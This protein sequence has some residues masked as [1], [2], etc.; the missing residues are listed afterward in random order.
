MKKDEPCPDSPDSIFR[1]PSLSPPN[2]LISPN[3]PN[4][5]ISPNLSMSHPIQYYNSK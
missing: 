4:L 3:S 1:C 5:S 2:L